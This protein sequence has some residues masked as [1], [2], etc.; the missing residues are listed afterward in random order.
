MKTAIVDIGTNTVLLLI[1]EIHPDKTFK[2]LCDKARIARLGEG[3]NHSG[4]LLPRAIKRTLAVLGDY[5]IKMDE[6]GCEKRILVGTAALR[7]AKNAHKFTEVVKTEC[8]L[9][10]EIIQGREEARLIHKACTRD[11][12]HLEKPLLVLDIGG[13]S[14][15]LIWDD[16][17][18]PHFTSLP[19]GTVNLTEKFIHSDP[20]KIS[21][22]ENLT[23]FIKSRLK[24]L[25]DA[26]QGTRGSGRSFIATAGTP[27]TLLAVQLGLK[28]YEAEKVHGQ[29]M[30]RD[31]LLK[32]RHRLEKLPLKERCQ[33]PCLPAGRADVIIA[34]SVILDTILDFFGLDAFWVS[35]R[36]LRYGLLYERFLS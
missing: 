34:G 33:I 22:I 12:S 20:P 1:A 3:R 26:G 24:N 23:R 13:G 2:I 18:K 10:V 35:D 8:D 5:K 30:T 9:E 19:F 32:L 25:P 6:F 21:E 17:R 27:T 11:F 4:R 36:G 28:I 15:E 29:K 14:T 7:N 31:A 16:N